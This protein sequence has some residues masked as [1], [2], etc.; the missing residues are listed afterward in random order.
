[1]R[2]QEEKTPIKGLKMFSS[3]IH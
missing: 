1:V 2:I 3:V